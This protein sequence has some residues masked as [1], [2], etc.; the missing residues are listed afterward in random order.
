MTSKCHKNKHFIYV[1]RS[2]CECQSSTLPHNV[3]CCFCRIF[4]ACFF[5]FSLSLSLILFD[6]FHFR[7]QIY[8]QI[9]VD[10]HWILVQI[11][12]NYL[13]KWH[14]IQIKRG[15]IHYRFILTVMHNKWIR[16]AVAVVAVTATAAATAN[17]NHTIYLIENPWAVHL[18]RWQPRD[19]QSVKQTKRHFWRCFCVFCIILKWQYTL[20][21]MI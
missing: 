9:I 19:R 4:F 11:P 15:K 2:K 5:S 3:Y 8:H 13:R 10:R 18:C 7:W 6:G 16:D 20:L 14:P 1:Y 21:S 12:T 17:M